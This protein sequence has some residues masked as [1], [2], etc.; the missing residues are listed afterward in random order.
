MSLTLDVAVQFLLVLSDF[1]EIDI[2]EEKENEHLSSERSSQITGLC[3]VSIVGSDSQAS[4]LIQPVCITPG[5][6][7]LIGGACLQEVQKRKLGAVLKC[8]A[9]EEW[10]SASVRVLHCS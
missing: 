6:S 3:L 8:I 2:R 4:S 9:L 7:L 10:R 5:L 1:L